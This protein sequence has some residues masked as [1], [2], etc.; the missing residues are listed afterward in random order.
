MNFS[1]PEYFFLALIGFLVGLL[2]LIG[3]ISGWTRLANFYRISGEFM[4][5]RWRF[6]SAQ[7]IPFSV[8][9]KLGQRI[10]KAAGNA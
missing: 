2:I 5:E 6:Q 4:G 3:R 7:S 9:E 8:T 10:A 1:R